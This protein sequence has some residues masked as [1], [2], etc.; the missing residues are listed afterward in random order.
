[1]LLLAKTGGVASPPVLLQQC[2]STASTAWRTTSALSRISALKCAYVIPTWRRYYP[3]RPLETLLS[4]PFHCP[5]SP[6]RRLCGGDVMGDDST[7]P[8]QQAAAHQTSTKHQCDSRSSTYI[9]Y[10]PASS[11]RSGTNTKRLGS[12]LMTLSVL[13]GVG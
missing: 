2:C 10:T 9:S 12:S 11:P 5:A 8:S 6:T 7:A 4:P 13:V 3:W 1:M